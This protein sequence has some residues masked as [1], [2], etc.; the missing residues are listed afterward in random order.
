MR[1]ERKE[2]KNDIG[3]IGS[4]TKQPMDAQAKREYVLS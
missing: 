3:E 1:D 2:V 4:F